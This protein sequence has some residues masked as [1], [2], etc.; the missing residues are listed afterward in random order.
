MS[1]KT[2][3]PATQGE[4]RKLIW[5]HRDTCDLN[6]IDTSLITDMS[7]LFEGDSHFNCRIDQWD[8]SNVTSMESMFEYA[9]KFNQP[10]GNWNVSKVKD[11][12]WLFWGATR[13]DQ[14]ISRWDV[15]SVT[16]LVRAFGS[17][18]DPRRIIPWLAKLNLK[19]VDVERIFPVHP[20]IETVE[21]LIA[22]LKALDEDTVRKYLS[23]NP[24]ARSLGLLNVKPRREKPTDPLQVA[25]Q[26]AIE[27]GIYLTTKWLVSRFGTGL[28]IKL[29]R[30]FQDRLLPPLIKATKVRAREIS[31]KAVKIF[32][33]P[34][35]EVWP[36]LLAA[37]DLDLGELDSDDNVRTLAAMLK[38]ALT[39]ATTRV[40]REKL[41]NW[42]DLVAPYVVM[43]GQ[44]RSFLKADEFTTFYK[45][46]FELRELDN[47]K[48]AEEF[49]D[50]ASEHPLEVCPPDLVYG[51]P[52]RGLTDREFLELAFWSLSKKLS[53]PA[54]TGVVF[55]PVTARALGYQNAVVMY[56]DKSYRSSE[57][58]HY[59]WIPKHLDAY[60]SLIPEPALLEWP[61]LEP[62]SVIT[63]LDRTT[64]KPLE[65]RWVKNLHDYQKEYIETLIAAY[66]IKNGQRVTVPPDRTLH[67]QLLATNWGK[68][69]VKPIPN[70]PWWW[71]NPMSKIE[72]TPFVSRTFYV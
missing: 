7:H 18:F 12:S 58:L 61:G 1:K 13:F 21:D 44:A 43:K 34:E 48:W 62:D 56:A 68:L 65:V 66:K 19:I 23:Q 64:K 55:D 20:E 39:E 37:L 9:S 10:I 53:I 15:S 69:E 71:K 31:P 30:K 29:L 22:Y 42:W 6:F 32:D 17:T 2:V 72:S 52:I 5:E 35:P 11:M 49:I 33:N 38:E 36:R 40:D 70:P 54:P 24:V 3:K 8:T 25:V 28:T 67:A 50:Y 46:L 45:L 14:D 26:L 51:L 27:E 4:L 57:F 41:G 59:Y 47:K 60:R 16:T 63:V